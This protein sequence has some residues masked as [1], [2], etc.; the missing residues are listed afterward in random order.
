MM[1]LQTERKYT[2]VPSA[3]PQV[4]DA[5]LALA[6]TY[7]SPLMVGP[8]M[9]DQLIELIRHMYTEEE[10]EVVQHIRPMRPRTAAGL[11]KAS[12]MP[13][14]K[15]EKL[16]DRLAHEL[17]VLLAVGNGK[18]ERFN[19]LPIVPGTFEAVM[20]RPSTDSITEW[21]K[22]FAELYEALFDTGYLK[23]YYT[24][25]APFVR[26]IPVG[27]VIDA[28]PM[29]MPSD[30]LESVL[31]EFDCY[32]IAVCQCRISKQL[33]GEGCGRKLEVCTGFGEV[34]KWLVD[35]GKAV[36]AS[37]RDVLETKA[38]AESQGLVTWMFNV[39]NESRI[40]GSCSC[41][42]CCCGAL[43]SIT[44]FNMPGAIA[45]AHFIPSIEAAACVGCGKCADIC[46]VR[47]IE[48][49]GEPKSQK[50]THI[51]QRCIGCG[52]CAVACSKSS[53]V[54]REAPGYV[55][56]NPSW[57]RFALRSGPEFVRVMRR[58]TR[59]RKQG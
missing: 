12:H 51:P 45:P 38:E 27:E 34:S 29:A 2:M 30:K 46:P 59:Q 1:E 44:Q 37:K 42:G 23:E 57:P 18:S 36:R 15:V 31:D 54:M 20:M 53:I 52:L 26:Y 41:C 49:R 6:R 10:A 19:I 25:K 14:W 7:A 40:N 48:M 24:D 11:A 43:R 35:N 32:S 50:P 39:G 28:I 13:L 55:E 47:A 8:P 33:V 22:R 5:H 4:T 9:S 16:L 56:P 3:S 17:F 21:H 58:V